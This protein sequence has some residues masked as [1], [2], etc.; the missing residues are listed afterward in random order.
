MKIFKCM[1]NLI[2][3]RN[4]NLINSPFQFLC[5]VEYYKTNKNINL[6][7]VIYVGYCSLSSK[8]QIKQTNKAIYKTNFEIFYLDEIF[9]IKIFH[10]IFFLLK[11]IKRKFL[12]CI[13]G[14]AKYYLFKEFVKKSKKVIFLD[15]GF[16][17][18]Y[19]ENQEKIEKYD[20]KI[21]TIFDI[22]NKNLNFIKNNLNYLKSFKKEETK[23]NQNLVFFLGTSFF[24]S[25]N[26]S[27]EIKKYLEDVNKRFSY[28]E[29]QY[30]PHRSEKIDNELFKKFKIMSIDAPIELHVLNCDQ[31]PAII[32]GFYSTALFTL[33]RIIN[34]DKIKIININFSLDSH[35]WDD[36]PD[37]E[38]HLSFTKILNKNGVENFY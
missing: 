6:N 4:F 8:N 15:E 34:N 27:G 32:C 7:N 11:K 14:T 9:N 38:K 25:E 13:C 12:F 30:F 24:E 17:L 3:S 35:N 21:F 28:K 20:S 23:I 33:K 1:L 36:S 2:L 10:F 22:E 5:F 18:T 29:I 16:D 37:V 19:K 31:L 26:R